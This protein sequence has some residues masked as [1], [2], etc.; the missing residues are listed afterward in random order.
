MGASPLSAGGA[1]RPPAP[2]RGDMGGRGGGPP[3]TGVAG[4]SARRSST[5][6]PG[7]ARCRIRLPLTRLIR[8][9]SPRPDACAS[10]VAPAHA[11]AERSRSRNAQGDA[12]WAASGRPWT[13]RGRAINKEKESECA[14]G[15]AAEEPRSPGVASEALPS[16]SVLARRPPP[17]PRRLKCRL[18]PLGPAG[19]NS[20]P[21]MATL[22]SRL[23]F[24]R[25]KR[26][27]RIYPPTT[28]AKPRRNGSGRAFDRI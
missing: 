18:R 2:S 12:V 16:A 9:V 15:S 7:L 25:D 23:S 3:I 22:V 5:C 21:A 8:L 1:R 27:P 6:A 11:Q 20:R 17:S 4:R 24:P 10:A 13:R 26:E 14:H 19:A 28:S